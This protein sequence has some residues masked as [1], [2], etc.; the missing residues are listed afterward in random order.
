MVY[1]RFIFWIR[2]ECFCYKTVDEIRFSAKDKSAVMVSTPFMSI[3]PYFPVLIDGFRRAVL[4][5]ILVLPLELIS[6]YPPVNGIGFHLS[7][8]YSSLLYVQY[9]PQRTTLPNTCRDTPS[10]RIVLQQPSEDLTSP[11]HPATQRRSL[12]LSEGCIVV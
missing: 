9:Y 11:W 6:T 3:T 1:K 2:D 4:G 7:I 12:C 8:I 5:V 10:R